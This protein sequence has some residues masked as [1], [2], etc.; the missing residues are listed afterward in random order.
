MLCQEEKGQQCCS[1]DT[2]GTAPYPQWCIRMLLKSVLLGRS[3]VREKSPSPQL[4]MA[5]RGRVAKSSSNGKQELRQRPSSL[6]P[7]GPGWA[8]STCASPAL[9]PVQQGHNRALGTILQGHLL[10]SAEV[11]TP[12]ALSLSNAHPV[13][14]GRSRSKQQQQ[15][16]GTAQ[17]GPGSAPILETASTRLRQPGSETHSAEPRAAAA[18]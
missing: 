5:D 2:P 12:L 16:V 11:L 7:A 13:S 18:C 17:G 14:L 3:K 9:K 8:V 1:T 6:G 15:P 10:S 4:P